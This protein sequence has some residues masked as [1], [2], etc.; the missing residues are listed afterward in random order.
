MSKIIGNPVGT[1]LPKP[2]WNQNDPSKGDYIKNKPFGEESDGV[3]KT[4]DEKFIPDSIARAN[5]VDDKFDTL[6]GNTPV[7]TQ[8]NEALANIDTEVSWND[9]T[10]KPFSETSNKTVYYSGDLAS[11]DDWVF[12]GGTAEA[13]QY[14]LNGTTFNVTIDGVTYENVP[15]DRFNAG[16]MSYYYYIGNPTIATTYPYV[17]DNGFPFAFCQYEGTT[18]PGQFKHKTLT[19][20]VS[21][22]IYQEDTTIVS[23]D[24]KFLPD[25]V[26]TVKSVNGITPDETGNVETIVVHSDWNI[27]DENDAGYI[28]N[29]THYQNIVKDNVWIEKTT[30]EANE[31]SISGY[32]SSNGAT[33]ILGNAIYP[34]LQWKVVQTAVPDPGTVIFGNFSLYDATFEDNGLPFCISWYRRSSVINVVV[35]DEIALPTT[36]EVFNGTIEYVPLDE[37]YIPDVYMKKSESNAIQIIEFDTPRDFAVSSTYDRIKEL[38]ENGVCVLLKDNSMT[39]SGFPCVSN[40][41]TIDPETGYMSC[42]FVTSGNSIYHHEWQDSFASIFG[43]TTHFENEQGRVLEWTGEHSDSDSYY[44]S[45]KTMAGYVD[46]TVANQIEQKADKSEVTALSALVGTTSVATQVGAGVTSA[47]SYTDEKIAN[48]LDNSSEAVDSIYEL[49][50]AMED[51]ADA[52]AALETIAGNKASASDLT[53][54]TSNKNNPHEVNLSQLG[55]TATAAELNIMDGVTATT[56]ELNY[57]DGVTS[58]IQ[59]QLD[60]KV[61]TSRKVNGKA[62]SADITLS[63]SDVGADVSG[64]ASNALSSAKSYTDAEITEWVGTSTV[65]SQINTAVSTKANTSDLTSHTTNATAHITA[66]E[67]TNWNAAKTHADSDHAPSDAEPNQNAFSNVTVGSTTI[68]ADS[69][70]DTLT[71]AGSNVTITPDTTSDKVTIGITKDNVTAALGYTPPTADTTYSAAGSSLGLVKSGGDVTISDGVITVK[72]DSHA[73]VIS[74]VDGLQTALDAKAT[75][76][77]LS[78]LKTLVGTTA[79]STQIA[80]AIAGKSDVGHTHD[81]Q[82]YTE[83]EIDT[84]LSGKSD[85]SHTHDSYVNQNAFGKVKVGSSTITADSTTDTLT[86]TA[87][88]NITL[89]PDTSGD[90]VTITAKDT[91]YTHPTSGVTAGTYKSVTVDANGHVTKGTNPTTLAG[92]GITD[93][94]AKDHTHE[95]AASGHDHNDV[96]YTETEIDSKFN[97]LVGT[98]SVSSQISSAIA[99]KVDKVSGKG[100][101]TNDLTAT[102]KSNYDAAYTHSQKTTG[103]PHKVTKSDVGLGNVENKSSATIRGEITKENVTTALGFTPS[104]STH[105]HSYIP[106]SEKGANS[107]VATLDANGKVP[108]SQLPSYVDDVLEYA[109][110]ASFPATGETGKIYIAQDTNKTYRWSGSAYVVISET[111]ALGETSSTAYAGNKGKANAEAITALQGLVGTTAVSTQINN[112]IAETKYAGSSSVGGSATSAVK[113]DTSTA[114]SATQPVYFTSGKPKACTHTLEASVPSNAVFTDTKYTAGSGLSLD[115]TTFKNN[116]AI[117]FVP[118]DDFTTTAGSSTSGS[119]LSTKWS[120]TDV[121]GIKTPFDGMQIAVRVPAA[122]VSTAGVVLSING[123]ASGSYYPV[124]RLVNSSVSTYYGVNSTILLTFN[125]SQTATAYL[126]SNTSST[127]TGCWQIA[128]YNADTKTTAGTSNKTGA[129]MYLVGGTSQSSSGVTT[130]TNKNCY[131]GTDNALYSNGSKVAIDSDVTALETLVGTTAVSTQISNALGTYEFITTDDIDTICG[132]SI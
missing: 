105:T 97:T 118:K 95:Y 82:Y 45:M 85:T 125:A 1:T 30:L 57:V 56:A 117:Y 75:A 68:A 42:E 127:V 61:P 51:N 55:V 76:S 11:G 50:D 4:L 47:N 64:S 107:G 58:N 129:K 104:E 89:T 28:K 94:A 26:G 112:A 81:D 66:T 87:G 29:R 102:L 72:D 48:L 103:N 98:T 63:A 88:D 22:E 114:G 77:D 60:A 13:E 8:I 6:V 73:H 31:Q 5:D 38:V 70:M 35:T 126:S 12:N 119:Y 67:R 109:K 14:R 59:T 86:L 69:K 54:H 128:D 122:G 27:N 120:V 2:N 37:K 131:V 9:L 34:N 21:V 32:L 108:T 80:N 17:N 43:Y 78:D 10:D 19:D 115:G 110:Q 116:A 91:V 36:L 41:V 100:L 16:S 130:Y 79:V 39:H 124:V 3:I 15:V 7:S 62:L 18:D 96:Y 53:S 113:L 101:S 33:I 23:L 132:G 44:P 40:P 83:A 121:D 90:S 106:T 123:G 93:A 92:Y 20:T 52:I 74:N 65:A 25:S 99:N 49:R 24:A 111:L 84:K 71:L 46:E